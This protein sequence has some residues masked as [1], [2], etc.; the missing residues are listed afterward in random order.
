[1]VAMPAPWAPEVWAAAFTPPKPSQSR[2]HGSTPRERWACAAGRPLVSV[3]AMLNGIDVSNWQGVVDW[4]H[5]ARAGVSFAFAKATE[6]VAFTDPWF[7]RNW[8]G[9]RESWIVCG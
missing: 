8:T 5:H 6:G 2:R 7:G 9:M 1:M 4:G 3:A